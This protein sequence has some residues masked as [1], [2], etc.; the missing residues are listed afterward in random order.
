MKSI[1]IE[2]DRARTVAIERHGYRVSAVLEQTMYL[3]ALD[4]VVDRIRHDV[5]LPAS[6]SYDHLS[7]SAT[8][9]PGPSPQGGGEGTAPDVSFQGRE[10]R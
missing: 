5:R 10:G 3:T 4:G 1:A 2:R 6:L 8:P 7:F 9:T